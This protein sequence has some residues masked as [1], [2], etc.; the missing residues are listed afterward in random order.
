[1]FNSEMKNDRK[2]LVTF[3]NQLQSV[4]MGDYSIRLNENDC[5]IKIPK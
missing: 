4:T 1:M 3:L 5:G 2:K